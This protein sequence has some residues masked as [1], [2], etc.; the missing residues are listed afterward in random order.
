M[1]R[2]NENIE[3]NVQTITWVYE[4][5]LCDENVILLIPFNYLVK[6]NNMLSNIYLTYLFYTVAEHGKT[7]VH[8]VFYK[9]LGK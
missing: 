4:Q 9:I 5:L 8:Y 2:S 6:I 1:H 3:E 7:F